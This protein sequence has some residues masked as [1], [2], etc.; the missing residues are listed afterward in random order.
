MTKAPLIKENISLGL[1]YSFRDSVLYCHGKKHGNMHTDMVLELRVLH[2][3][4]QVAE[5]DCIP[6]WVK[7][8][9]KRD[10]KVHLNSDTLPPVR[11]HLL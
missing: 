10:L 3:E 7:L 8:K 1:A 11:P 2:L 6:Y 5:G 9:H 4:P